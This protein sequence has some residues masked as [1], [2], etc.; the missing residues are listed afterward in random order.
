MPHFQK[1][2]CKLNENTKWGVEENRLGFSWYIHLYNLIAVFPLQ[3]N[4]ITVFTEIGRKYLKNKK[5]M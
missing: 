3:L 2:M 1:G 4:Y 5:N